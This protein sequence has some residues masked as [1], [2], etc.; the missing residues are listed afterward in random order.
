MTEMLLLS[1]SSLD[2]PKA[3]KPR[4]FEGGTLISRQAANLS[5]RA[6]FLPLEILHLLHHKV[7]SDYRDKL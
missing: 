7:Q 4:E 3:N 5:Y 6:D 2:I 1:S